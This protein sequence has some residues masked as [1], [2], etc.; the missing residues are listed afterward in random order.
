[1]NIPIFVNKSMPFA[2]TPLTDNFKGGRY[3]TR[4]QPLRGS[5]LQVI[6]HSRLRCLLS[7]APLAP[8][9]VMISTEFGRGYRLSIAGRESALIGGFRGADRGSRLATALLGWARELDDVERLN[10]EGRLVTITG[11]GGIGKARL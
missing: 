5:L 7:G 1:M 2:S 11:P 10:A 8:D 6:L 4:K 3:W 9:W